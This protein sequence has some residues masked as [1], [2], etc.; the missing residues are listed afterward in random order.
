M[1]PARRIAAMECLVSGHWAF[2]LVT[3]EDGTTGIGEAT[4]FTHPNALVPIVADLAPAYFGEDAFRAEFLFQRVLKQHCMIDAAAG[5][6][7]SAID[8][9]LWDI[10]GKVL[11]APVWE[12]LGGRVRDRV[13]AIVLVQAPD[14]EALVIEALRARDDGFTAMKI[15]P[16]IGDWARRPTGAMLREVVETVRAVRAAIGWEV[17][18]AVEVHR[19]LNAETA[20]LF[21]EQVRDLGL[22]FIEDPVQPFSLTVNRHVARSLRQP[23]AL[24]ERNLNIWEFREFS[25]EP[26]VTILRPDAGVA[27]GITQLRKIAAI[28]E[29][30]HQR[31]VPHN[32]TSPVL[33]AVHVQLAACTV[34]WDVQG[35]VR[36]Q[37]E[38]WN[39]VVRQINRL[40]DGF[41]LIPET[42]GIGMELHLDYVRS[43]GP[44]PFGSQFA[45]IAHLGMD[46]G[47]RQV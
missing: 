36:E 31:I 20:V 39:R 44:V 27:G 26:A 37:R 21:A 6:A 5:A 15:K 16:F 7:L 22:Y 14:A 17:D 30:R 3:T 34:N 19:N 13:R 2:V 41:L 4:Y 47:L 9:A 42:P 12:L 24:A 29:S 43:H 18:L 38:P 35:Y 8:Q 11:G 32:F 40:E 25:D 46:G 33:T 45:H 10:K 23:I 28:A 1:N